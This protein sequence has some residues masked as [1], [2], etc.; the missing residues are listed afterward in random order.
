MIKDIYNKKLYENFD[1]TVRFI[2]KIFDNSENKE[3]F[4]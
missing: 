1:K 4:K 3:I 2:K